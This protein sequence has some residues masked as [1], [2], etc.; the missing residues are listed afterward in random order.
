MKALN[1][2]CGSSGLDL[3]SGWNWQPM[4]CGMIGNLD[5]LD[6]GAV[7]S[8]AG[9]AQAARG[10]RALIFAV[11]FVAVAVAL[12]DFG[13]VRRSCGRGFR[14]DLARPRAQAH[15]AAQFL[16]AAQF[17]QLVDHAMRSGGI[18]FAGIGVRQ[19]ANIARKLDARRL[20]AQADAEVG[21]FILA[22]IAD[23][24][25]A[26]LQCRA[27]QI[28]RAPGCRRSLP[29]APRTADPVASRPRLQ[30]SSLQ[31]QVVRQRAVHQRFFQRLVGVFVFDVLADD[32]DGD[33]VFRVVHAVHESLPTASGR[34]SFA[35]R[36]RYFSASVSTFSCA[37]TSGTS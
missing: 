18:E 17:A 12:A 10:Q 13:S 2:G 21:N 11:E 30:S 26:C 4:K 35:S 20:H 1:N 27:C 7:G 14:L 3:N 15:G 19:S 34:G 36:C 32:A 24:D 25:R 31:L 29:T 5:H 8:G 9:N 6:V 16:D 28:R 22:R 23:G 33:F 37:N